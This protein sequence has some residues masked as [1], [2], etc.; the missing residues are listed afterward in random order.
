MKYPISPSEMKKEDL[1]SNAR[2]LYE[3]MI[4]QGLD[5]D[6]AMRLLY[7][8][9][10]G[11]DRDEHSIRV[12]TLTASRRNAARR[13]AK[14]ALAVGRSRAE[15][16]AETGLSSGTLRSLEQELDEEIAAT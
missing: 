6:E 9:C 8:I 15:I 13:K 7:G 5:E 1:T 12:P 16:Q 2:W 11:G 4:Q 3:K 10:R 14:T